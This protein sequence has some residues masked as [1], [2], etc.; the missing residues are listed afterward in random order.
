MLQFFWCV[1]AESSLLTVLPTVLR[2]QKVVL[3]PKVARWCHISNILMMSL[4]TLRDHFKL[5]EG[6]KLTAYIGSKTNQQRQGENPINYFNNYI[7][8]AV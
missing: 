7:F 6:H 4:H 8:K 1:S 3:A 2:S 5:Y